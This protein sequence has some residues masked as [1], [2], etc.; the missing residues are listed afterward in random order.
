M[1]KLKCIETSTVDSFAYILSLHYGALRLRVYNDFL[2]KLEK[3]DFKSV[4][5]I[6]VIAFL[7]ILLQLL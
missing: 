1:H 4:Y 6:R 3:L 2:E 7:L 5:V